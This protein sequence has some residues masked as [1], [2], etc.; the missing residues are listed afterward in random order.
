VLGAVQEY[1]RAM[2]AF[3]VMSNLAVWHTVPDVEAIRQR[4]ALEGQAEAL[5]HLRHR[6]TEAHGRD[7]ARALERLTRRVDGHWQIVS[8]PPLVVRFEDLLPVEEHQRLDN[9]VREFI[10]PIEQACSST[11]VTSWRNIAMSRSR[12]K[13]SASA[14]W[15]RG[16]GSSCL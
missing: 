16:P 12:A 3:A 8:S 7:N 11:A 15:A 5:K 9:L 14:A 13:R 4:L 2:R 10:R 6:V 1:Q